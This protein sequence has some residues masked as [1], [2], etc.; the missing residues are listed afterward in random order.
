MMT[1]HEINSTSN[2]IAVEQLA[3]SI[4]TGPDGSAPGFRA[5]VTLTA[6]P[7]VD[8]AYVVADLSRGSVLRAR[9]VRV[10]GGGQGVNVQPSPSYGIGFGRS[11]TGWGGSE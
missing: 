1:G 3:A 10:D 11:L 4:A 7:S 8:R 6:N 9:S 5:I 2:L